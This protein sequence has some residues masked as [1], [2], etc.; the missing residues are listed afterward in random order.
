[1]RIRS[2]SQG[3][4]LGR[5]N[6]SFSARGIGVLFA[7]VPADGRV[8]PRRHLERLE[9]ESPPECG[10][11]VA[12]AAAA[13]LRPRLEKVGVIGGI[14]EHR[15]ALVVLGGGAQQRDAADVDVLDG[16]RGRAAGPRDRG[17]EGVQVADDD[18][19][20]R[21]GVR[22]EVLLVGGDVAGEDAWNIKKSTPRNE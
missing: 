15:D 19:D 5:S 7:E 4:S 16:V 18:G 14:R 9:R 22:R 2:I 8:V 12:A 13:A 10:A 17:R 20:R 11:D 1:V 21:D 6:E 3:Q